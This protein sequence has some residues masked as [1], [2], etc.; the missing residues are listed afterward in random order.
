VIQTLLETKA[1]LVT[2][3]LE[4]FQFSEK[5]LQVILSFRQ[6]IQSSLQKTPSFP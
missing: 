5:L 3:G 2:Q 6:G 1:W 4:I